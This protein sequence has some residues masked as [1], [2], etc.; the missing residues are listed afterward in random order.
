MHLML[1]I[2]FL[3]TFIIML[4]SRCLLFGDILRYPEYPLI[5]QS[6][7]RPRYFFFIFNLYWGIA[8]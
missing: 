5:F 4:T 2:C 6:G 7:F 3:K 8:D 1:V